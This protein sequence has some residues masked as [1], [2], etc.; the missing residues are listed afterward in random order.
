MPR[1]LRHPLHART[2]PGASNQRPLLSLP[3]LFAHRTS[4]RRPLR[5]VPRPRSRYIRR[6]GPESELG[7]YDFRARA[8][9]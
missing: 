8:E 1:R 4:L 7:V 5:R 6:D 9:W 3:R 2:S